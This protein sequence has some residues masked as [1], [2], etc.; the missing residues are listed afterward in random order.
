MLR[1]LVEHSLKSIRRYRLT[2]LYIVAGVTLATA[3]TPFAFYKMPVMVLMQSQDST[4]AASR[5]RDLSQFQLDFGESPLIISFHVAR[6]AIA[7]WFAFLGAFWDARSRIKEWALIR[8]YGGYPSLVAGFQYISLALL[9]ALIGGGFALLTGMPLFPNDAFRLL[10]L[11]MGWGM[12]FAI[13]VSIG[14]V[15]YTE[16]CD[17]V[18]IFRMEGEVK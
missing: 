11:T 6:I 15:L 14:P 1:F 7:G 12:V 17:V 13:A 16:L 4:H 2:A 8:L 3:H 5:T 18:P 10:V 9:G